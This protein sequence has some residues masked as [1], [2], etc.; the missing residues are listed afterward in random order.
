MKWAQSFMIACLLFFLN[1]AAWAQTLGTTNFL[2]GPAAG[3]DSVVLAA[4]GAWTATTNASW[5]HL[6]P[7]YQSGTDSTN[8]IFSF[9][10]NSGST[11]S[12]TLTIDGQTLAVTQAG[13]TYVATT[14]VFNLVSSGLNG[15]GAVAVDDLGNVY[16]ADIGNNAIKEWMVAGNSITTLV[17]SGLSHPQGVAVDGAGNIYIADSYNNAIKKWTPTNNSVS[18]LVSS[19]LSLPSSVA[20]DGVGNLYFSDGPNSI[21]EWIKTSNT[22][23]TLVYLVNGPAAG[24]SLDAAG[25]VYFSLWQ[26]NTIQEWVRTSKA[27]TILLSPSSGLFYPLSEAVDGSGNVYIADTINNAIKERTATTKSV[28]TLVSS[29]IQPYGVAV[30]GTGNVYIADYANNA[31]KE[32]P[33][34]FID[35]TAIT[36]SP[37]AGSDVLPTVLPVTANLTGP[38][39]PVSDSPWLTFTVVTNGVIRFAFTANSSATN[40]TANITL[41][42][43]TIL[44]TQA[45]IMPPILTGFTILGNGAF[46]FGFSNN[47]SASFTVWTTTN[48][49]LPLTNWTAL[50]PPVNI[51]SGQYNFT[52]PA[53]TNGGQSFYRVSFP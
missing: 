34:A 15:P 11:R 5:L 47:S 52:D 12:G 32:L 7:A 18:T 28:S 25:N 23:S 40:R 50:R 26:F 2:E 13:S 1:P 37:F 21:K 33:H 49:S 36:E 31:I 46:Q 27:V 53:A 4:N 48:L 22:V 16:I 24:V 20:V 9:D 35:P 10:A 14:I 45:A 43:Q 41:L 6:D 42:G 38:F 30:D 39:A 19:G 3:S 51:G 17:S 8:L 29:G 44:V